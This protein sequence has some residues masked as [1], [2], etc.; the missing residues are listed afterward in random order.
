MSPLKLEGVGLSLTSG[1]LFSPLDLVAQPGEIVSILG[2]S[3]I[4]KSSLLMFVCGIL[5]STFTTEGRVKLGEVDKTGLPPEQRSI[6]LLEQDDL[7]FPHLSVERNL[8]FGLARSAA[9]RRDRRQR[10]A[11]ALASFGLEGFGPRDPATLSGGQRARVALLRVLLSEPHALLLDEP[12]ARLDTQ[13]RQSV[14]RQVFEEIRARNIPCLLVTHDEGDA[15]A[16]G[17][18]IVH[19]TPPGE[20]LCSTP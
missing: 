14:R 12:F 15:Q 17:G 18:P 6:G 13:T 2:A 4:G 3:G 10:I 9:G 20:V 5:P 8:A 16:A 19:L 7:L 1:K 11:K